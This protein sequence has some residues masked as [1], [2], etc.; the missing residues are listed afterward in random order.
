M[1]IQAWPVG[2]HGGF[3]S[4]KTEPKETS[5]IRPSSYAMAGLYLESIRIE[6]QSREPEVVESKNK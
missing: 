3:L 4:K 1:S 2:S 5:N 6:N